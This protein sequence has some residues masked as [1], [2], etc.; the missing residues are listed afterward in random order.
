MCA[1]EKQNC[2]QIAAQLNAKGFTFRGKDWNCDRVRQIVRR[3]QYAGL[4]VWGRRKVSHPGPSSLRPKSQWITGRALDAAIVDETT[5]QG[6]QQ[7]L[8]SNHIS[9][10]SEVLLNNLK[11]I[12]RRHRCL[13]ARLIDRSARGRV[14]VYADRF[15]SLLKAYELVGYKASPKSYVMS[16][17]CRQ[18]NALYNYVLSEIQHL[19]P[20]EVRLLRVSNQRRLI[21]VDRC[22]Q[23]SVFI[24]GRQARSFKNQKPLWLLRLHSD[25]RDHVALVC[26]LDSNWANISDYYV[27]P[28]MRD[29][30]RD[31]SRLFYEND[32]WLTST[33]ERLNGLDD[34][35]QVVRRQ[36]VCSS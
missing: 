14:N 15:G 16:Y 8:A 20:S 36:S 13:S 1:N 9:Y 5:F 22:T 25:D 31:A 21:E 12:L 35:V 27:L 6:A 24:C 4:N 2:P 23:V 7:V 3:A 32:G 18:R 11:R 29:L 33:G 26:K 30:I 17:H 19:F 10:T 28:P 34:F